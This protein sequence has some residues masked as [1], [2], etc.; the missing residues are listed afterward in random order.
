MQFSPFKMAYLTSLIDWG[1]LINNLST[2]ASIDQ[3]RTAGGKATF[4]RKHREKRVIFQIKI[5]QEF[6]HLD[7]V[8]ILILR[9]KYF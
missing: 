7:H 2:L 5:M 3:V 1:Q 9:I 6:E 4:N 8:Y